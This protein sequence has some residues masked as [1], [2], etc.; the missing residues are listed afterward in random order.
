MAD[1]IS[2][3][4]SGGSSILG[5]LFGSDASSDAAEA[6]MY[7]ADQSNAI[8]KWMYKRTRK[9]LAPWRQAGTAAINFVSGI[10]GIPGYGTTTMTAPTAPKLEDYLMKGSIGG[11]QTGYATPTTTDRAGNV[12]SADGALAPQ[13]AL[14]SGPQ[15]DYTAYN[16]ALEKYQK[17]L[18]S[19]EASKQQMTGDQI[20]NYLRET[21]GYQFQIKEGENAINKSLAA[22]GGLLSGGSL[23]A[24]TEYREGI[25]DQTYNN[26]LNRLMGVA[27]VGQS[28]VNTTAASGQNYANQASQNYMYAGNAQA[29]GYINQANALTGMTSGLANNFLLYSM[30]NK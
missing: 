12:I 10:L 24:L 18:A 23:K 28:A 5:G 3:I 19:Y 30:L 20:T 11:T 7:A 2:G 17:D 6:Q 13:N 22:K 4:I 14:A 21:P 15:Y 8:Q 1:A 27:G 29:T 26:W 16:A 9:D 25:A